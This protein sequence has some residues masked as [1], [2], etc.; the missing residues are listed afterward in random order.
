M[1]RFAL[2]A[3]AV[4]ALITVLA[5]PAL[6][7]GPD[8][9]VSTRAVITGPGLNGPIV[10]Q[11]DV[12]A[13]GFDGSGAPHNELADDLLVYSGLSGADV[14][15]YVFFPD[16]HTLGP[17][18]KITYTFMGS[19]SE[20]TVNAPLAGPGATIDLS[21]PFRQIV[22]PYAPER[23]LVYTAPGQ[24]FLERQVIVGNWW[25]APPALR[26]F[27]ISKGLPS[28]P[29]A[30]A[31][32]ATKPLPAGPGFPWAIAFAATALLAMVATA[33]VLVRRAQRPGRAS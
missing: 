24:F 25:S 1:K 26:T 5:V 9:R 33:A 29:A 7:K 27:L 3:T 2:I 21:V 22:Y 19:G 12:S 32:P 15:W 11:G 20:K 6:A 4:A 14:G 30:A 31:Q 8:V 10:V 18:Y 16:L 28:A 23:P 17:E 13:Y